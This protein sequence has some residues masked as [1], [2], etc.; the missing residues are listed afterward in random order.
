MKI[1][2]GWDH[3]QK[4]ISAV[5]IEDDKGNTVE[6]KIQHCPAVVSALK[7]AML[8]AVENFLRFEIL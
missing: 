1:Y 7:T 2:T 8:E 6:I 5:Y 4:K 3:T